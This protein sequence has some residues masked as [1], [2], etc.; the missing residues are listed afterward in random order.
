MPTSW[1]P[2]K[3][4]QAHVTIISFT[5]I[6]FCIWKVDWSPRLLIPGYRSRHCHSLHVS[7]LHNVLLNQQILVLISS[8]P[9][10]FVQRS[11]PR[12]HGNVASYCVNHSIW[13]TMHAEIH[14][15]ATLLLRSAPFYQYLL[16]KQR[17]VYAWISFSQLPTWAS[18]ERCLDSNSEGGRR[19]L[20]LHL[21]M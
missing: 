10:P 16:E 20:C 8:L 15:T 12:P 7:T 21:T 18:Y 19:R 1:S 2:T 6:I 11:L 14:V 4:Q 3:L 17:G 13:P 9:R 5:A